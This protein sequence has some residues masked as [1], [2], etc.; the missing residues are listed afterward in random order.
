MQA[1]FK[2]TRTMADGFTYVNSGFVYGKGDLG[3]I[4]LADVNGSS[5]KA[6]YNKTASEQ[7]SLTYGL[8]AQ[9]GT[10]T[11][12]AFLVYKDATGTHEVYTDPQT[13]DYAEL[14]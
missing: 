2:A 3:D 5:V 4:V 6:V 11:A 13:A 7:F 8:A 9:A 10:M 12:R 14:A 1:S